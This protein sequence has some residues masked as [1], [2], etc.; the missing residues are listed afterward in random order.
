MEQTA[1]TAGRYGAAIRAALPV[2]FGYL[3]LGLACGMLSAK[4]GLL[5]VQVLLLSTLLYAGGAQFMVANLH[6]AGVPPLAMALSIALMNARHVLY[7]S[8][9]AKHFVGRSRKDIAL[10]SVEL[11]DETFGVNQNLFQKGNWPV[12]YARTVNTISHASWIGANMA[13]V[14]LGEIISFPVSV[15]SFG[16]TAMFLCLLCMQINGRTTALTAIFSALAVVVCKCAGLGWIAVMAGS[17][18]GITAGVFVRDKREDK[19]AV[20]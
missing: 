20:A 11:T 7:G 17:L 6:M 8:A 10:F 15:I 9:L 19:H 13:G 2:C 1:D 3:A 12:T 4:A 5:P 14:L 16:M 18:C